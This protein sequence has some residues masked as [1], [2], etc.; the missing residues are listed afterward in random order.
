[1]DWEKN[2]TDW[3]DAL[4]VKGHTPIMEDWDGVEEIDMFVVDIEFCNGPGC[5]KCHW[6]TCQHCHPNLDDI[7]FCTEMV[8]I[9]H[10]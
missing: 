6:S 8:Q 3:Y 9:E 7:P 1:M 4:K 10:R 5:S 2:K